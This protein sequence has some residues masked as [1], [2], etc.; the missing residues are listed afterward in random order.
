MQGFHFAIM[1]LRNKR[2]VLRWPKDE[3]PTLNGSKAS[4]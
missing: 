4:Y 2:G 3:H 1:F